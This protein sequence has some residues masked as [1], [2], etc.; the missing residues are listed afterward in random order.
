MSDF[1][2]RTDS[3]NV[4]QIMEQIRARIREKRGVDYTEQ[5]IRDLA[6]MKL[7]TFLD[8][9]VVRSDLLERF[10]RA[11]AAQAAASHVTFGPN[12]IFD[13]E[14]PIVARIRRLLRP[15]LKL[16][17]NPNPISQA[18]VRLNDIDP[19][20][21]MCHEILHSLVIELTRTGIE[22][23]N[24]KMRVESLTGRLEFNERR[25]RALERAVAYVP[26]ADE[27]ASPPLTGGSLP[28]AAP[29]A[30]RRSGSF[31]GGPRPSSS[32][33]GHGSSASAVSRQAPSSVRPDPAT[34]T[35]QSAPAVPSSSPPPSAEQSSSPALSAGTP[36][37]S[38][39]GAGHQRGRRRR[40][41]RGRRSGGS[42]ATLEGATGASGDAAPPAGEISD[43]DA[44]PAG[45]S[46]PG[47]A[48]E[49]NP[50]SADHAAAP[51]DFPR[52]PSGRSDSSGEP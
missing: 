45:T 26:S 28:S 36:P 30:G 31:A 14:R 51:A 10:Q 33:H 4:E 18:L 46:G 48:F 22:V 11:Q 39:E 23:T 52:D 24:L 12:A 34:S 21:D 42:A 3:V 13:T 17:F 49:P 38:A 9:R 50:G 41:R 16:F 19:R 8:P 1:T 32:G 47:A 43:H 7:E 20:V 25:A 44:A 15:V 35:A 6:A 37:Q 29:N 27:Q 2:V 40:R 5:Q